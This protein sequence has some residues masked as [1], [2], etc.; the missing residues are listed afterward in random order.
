MVIFVNDNRV[1]PTLPLLSNTL[2]P[3]PLPNVLW[4]VSDLHI[5][6]R[7]AQQRGIVGVSV[8]GTLEHSWNGTRPSCWFGRRGRST[9]GSGHGR[10]SGPGGGRRP[11]GGTANR[12]G[13]AT[14]RLCHEPRVS[15]PL[16]LLFQLSR[17]PSFGLVE[18]LHT[19]KRKGNGLART[20]SKGLRSCAP[21]LRLLDRMLDCFGNRAAYSMWS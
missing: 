9:H 16:P 7:A 19:W 1:F 18:R 20:A 10:G 6:V 3:L 8:V 13:S 15:T 2:T 5:P 4:H 11:A 21:N 17:L 12:P 14:Q